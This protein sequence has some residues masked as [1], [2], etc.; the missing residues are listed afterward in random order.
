ME[1]RKQ[2]KDKK[3]RKEESRHH[4]LED[5]RWRDDERARKNF[6]H[7]W[8]PAAVLAY[9]QRL[10]KKIRSGEPLIRDSFW[11]PFAGFPPKICR[12]NQSIGIE[13]KAKR[14]GLD[15][16]HLSE[17]TP[18]EWAHKPGA[19]L[20]CRILPHQAAITEAYVAT[21]GRHG[22]S[23]LHLSPRRQFTDWMNTN[24]ARRNF[25][26]HPYV[27]PSSPSSNHHEEP[28]S[29]IVG[30]MSQGHRIF[31]ESCT[32]IDADANELST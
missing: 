24:D 12:K 19:P 1:K 27:E 17:V 28:S 20:W 2:R 26:L 22:E 3:K 5:K 32:P 7:S 4:A 14:R 30:V 23:P 6:D 31:H 21:A 25:F 10:H 15:L 13:S 18:P 16:A 29:P 8:T 11:P 9:G